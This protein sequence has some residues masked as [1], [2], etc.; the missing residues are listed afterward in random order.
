MVLLALALIPAFAMMLFNASETRNRKILETKDNTVR[1]SNLAAS[2]QDQLIGAARDILIT[3]AQVPAIQS[4]DRQACLFFLS[5]VLMQHPLYANFGAA[6]QDGTIFC[7]TWPQKYP[8]SISSEKYFQQAVQ[9]QDFIISEYYISEIN[10][11]AM[12]TL[13][14]PVLSETG[15]SQGIVFANLD[16]RWLGSFMNAAALPADSKLRVIDRE[17]TILAS[18]P[19]GNFEI[20]KKMA[21]EAITAEMVAQRK[22][23]IQKQDANGIERL[24]S[25]TTL[26]AGEGSDIFVL[27]SVPIEAALSESNMVLRQN[28]IA[29]FL[30]A[31]FALVIA[32]FGT[33]FFFLRQVK[34]LVNVTQKL[35]DGDL[36]A[37]TRWQYGNGE[38]DKLAIAFDEMAE[39]LQQREQEQRL[40]NQKI[41]HQK[42][43]AEALARITERLNTT[44]QLDKV[45]QAVCDETCL[46]MDASA[47]AVM[48]Y[49]PTKGQPFYIKESAPEEISLNTIYPLSPDVLER[50]ASYQH[51]NILVV[52]LF[53]HP[54]I[55][56]ENI[57]NAVHSRYLY[58]VNLIHEEKLIGRLDL[59]LSENILS[60][61]EELTFLKGIVNSAVLA[62]S[63]AQ[64]VTALKQEERNRANLLHKIIGA[65]ENERMRISRELHDETSQSLTALLLGLDTMEIASA[66]SNYDIHEQIGNLKGIS[67]DMLDNVHRLIADL[68][69]SLL[70]D[71]GLISAIEWYGEQRLKQKG[72]AFTLKEN[73]HKERFSRSVET[74]LFRIVQEGITNSL[75]HAS[76]SAIEIS[77]EKNNDLVNLEI[78][79]NG[80]GFD[81]SNLDSLDPGGRGWGVM[82][83]RERTAILG[84]RFEISSTIGK[85]TTIRIQFKLK[86]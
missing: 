22:G 8:Y 40:A 3:L 62:I 14:Y 26:E 5:N 75:R 39:T 20:G 11:E 67:V 19:E 51:E 70:D 56:P 13:A 47:V 69:P 27:I 83:M 25:Y 6:D 76:P 46:A 55:L 72:I 4:Q 7:M 50:S 18:Y 71:L 9:K 45:L 53:D 79:D 86:K 23:L 17:G 66:G 49:F 30:G 15:V 36:N 43:Q 81:L 64:L 31:V 33:N 24:Y 52:D 38:L 41:G 63:N 82:G 28:L 34:N 12:I 84:G 10:S 16:L 44:L 68:R 1:L 78:C 29:L 35:S 58:G 54:G 60:R 73:I 21:E 85:G 65:Q 80:T 37:R 61:Q 77:L 59:Y 2:N 32:W 57:G 74:T 48:L 42:E